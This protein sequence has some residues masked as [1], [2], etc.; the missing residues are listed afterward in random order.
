MQVNI[1]V[2]L[3]IVAASD[4]KPGFIYKGA[5]GLLLRLDVCPALSDSLKAEHSRYRPFLNLDSCVVVS[6]HSPETLLE[7]VGEAKISLA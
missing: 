4:T 7:E 6:I 1:P 3:N 2:K 5:R